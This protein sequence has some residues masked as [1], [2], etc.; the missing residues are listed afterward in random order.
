MKKR[1]KVYLKLF[2][3]YLG[4]LIIPILIASF[5]YSYTVSRI[6]IQTE[7]MNRTLLENTKADLDKELESI[8]KMTSH[9][10]MDTSIQQLSRVKGEFTGNDLLNLYYLYNDLSSVAMSEDFVN[11]VFVYFNN[12]QKISSR[13]GNMDAEFYYD[14]YCASNNYSWDDFRA[15]MGQY[16]NNDVLY[17]NRTAGEDLALFS[18]TV[19][20]SYIAEPAATLCV[21]IN[22]SQIRQR[23]LSSKWSDDMEVLILNQNGDKICQ[24]GSLL[25]NY[26]MNYEELAEGSYFKADILSE[27]CMVTVLNS[28][29]SDWKYIVIMPISMIDQDARNIQKVAM[30]GLF[31]CVLS[32]FAFSYILTR[33]NYNP[34]KMLLDTFKKHG[35]YDISDSDNE[36]QWLNQKIEY[37][38]QEH[39]DT[40]RVLSSNQKHLK[41][42]YLTRLLQ[43]FYDGKPIEQYGIR[44]NLEYNVVILISSQPGRP[45]LSPEPPHYEV[46]LRENALQRFVILNIF[47]EMCGN[48]FNLEILEMGEKVAA[49]ISLPEPDQKYLAILKEQIENLQQI[50]EDSFAFTCIALIGPICQGMA[51]IHTSYQQ[52]SE[53]EEYVCLLDEDLIQYEDVKNIQSQYDYPVELEKKIM[54]AMQVGDSQQAGESMRAVFTRNMNG[55]V[56]PDIYRCLIYDMIGTLLK[57][58]RQAGYL[59][60]A[61]DLELLDVKSIRLPAAEVAQVFQNHL[62]HICDEIKVRQKETSQDHSFSIKIEEYIR[63]HF[64]NPDLNISITS[65]HFD[66]TPSYLSSVYKK[67]TGRSLLDYIT[68]LRL[69]Y[70]ES[71][72]EDGLSVIEVA[73]K[74]GFRDSASFIRTFKKKRGITPGQIKKKF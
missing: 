57:G 64:Q 28:D 46:T 70:A 45:A 42:Y 1:S 69:E 40:Q 39:V 38:F 26:E 67:Q 68:T 34:L 35:N 62:N 41:Q 55:K 7:H 8:Q 54:Q 9:L 71:L 51:G 30:T 15:Y 66:I 47:E 33:R 43:E 58:A 2:I 74:A 6:R 22:F 18:V 48:Y 19:L 61:K 37:F 11:D 44:L 16:H 29:K 21:T 4:V 14:L 59:D 13:K 73:E 65:Q 72:L 32:S 50:T 36:Y 63:Q 25:E 60:A 5:I 10:R 12:T 23:L 53:L 3:S 27:D 20:D 17:L 49:I 31:L 24:E 52:A 56:S